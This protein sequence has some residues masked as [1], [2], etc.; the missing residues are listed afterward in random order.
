[1]AHQV[2]A[3][4][5]PGAV[6][7][8]GG[9]QPRLQVQSVPLL[10][11]RFSQSPESAPPPR[12]QP[13]SP[14]RRGFPCRNCWPAATKRRAI[15]YQ[16]LYMRWYRDVRN[17]H[18]KRHENKSKVGVTIF[19]DASRVWLG[20]KLFGA[21]T[22]AWS[23]WAALVFVIPCLVAYNVHPTAVPRSCRSRLSE[24]P[25]SLTS[26]SQPHHRGYQ[27]DLQLDHR[28]SF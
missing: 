23:Q 26:R 19:E 6:P 11:R 2:L 5:T 22:L 16:I 14:N 1:M 7:E 24:S 21:R 15:F 9:P 28:I 8:L 25:A 27:P 12:A 3:A 20:S 18:Q 10:P 4:P 13:G 17:C